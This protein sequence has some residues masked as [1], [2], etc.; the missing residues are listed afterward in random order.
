MN[1][2]SRFFAVL[3]PL[4]FV[5]PGSAAAGTPSANHFGVRPDA[6]VSLSVTPISDFWSGDGFLPL[7]VRVENRSRDRL[8]WRIRAE[9]NFGYTGH[10][11]SRET[12]IAADGG[13]VTEIV[14]M[15]PG[16]GRVPD[17]QR[18]TLH[19]IADGPGLESLSKIYLLHGGAGSDP[20]VNTAV[21][22][23]NETALFAAVNG[24]PGMHSEISVVRPELWPADWRV[25]APFDRVV[26]TDA[27]F[28][29]IDGPRRA[30]LRDWVAMGGVLD[31][32][33]E[34]GSRAE[35]KEVLGLG[36]IRRR[37][38]TLQAEAVAHPPVTR[39]EGPLA[40]IP[41]PADVEI[42]PERKR[43][44]ELDRGVLG[45]SFFLL[46][47]GVL[48]GP[49]N[50]FVFAPSGRRHRLFL[51][52]PLISFAA[53]V[54][55][56]GFIVVQDGFGGEGERWGRVLLSPDSNQ[57]VVRQVQ[58][59]RT[60][61]LLGD[62]F[63]LPE[64]VKLVRAGIWPTHGY[65]SN[66]D[67]PPDHYQ[68]SEGTAGGDWFTSRRVQTHQLD[69]LVPT[70]ARVELLDAGGGGAAP[71]VQSSLGTVLRDFRFSDASGASWGAD[72]VPPGQRV[73]L[74]P[75][76]QQTASDAY[77]FSLIPPGYFTAVGGEA[78]GLTPI[79]TLDSIRW[80][81]ANFFYVGP[82]VGARHP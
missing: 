26:L 20:V 32:Y 67:P 47:F 35:T 12:W 19:L 81:P 5:P 33:P 23:G 72:E 77:S 29:A 68:R 30:A 4:L 8:E 62:E 10:D 17:G 46:G 3:S 6:P 38:S 56:A 37:A 60:G 43:A 79:P 50:L 45:V 36:L 76:A 55:L 51:T 63:E 82:L 1:F 28:D 2:V 18:T 44:L 16:G 34:S 22:P 13:E 66:D 78:E 25:W 42:T 52:V 15:I 39:E 41:Y 70:R 74:R 58:Y 71:V 7:L 65:R 75:L 27:E 53:S 61:V 80:E 69:R 48:V 73:T 49:V 24:A 21:S 54:L 9:A 40:R 14:M 31:L 57:A 59:S 11:L 64:D